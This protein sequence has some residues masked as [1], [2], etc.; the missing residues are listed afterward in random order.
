[1]TAPVRDWTSHELSYLEKNAASKTIRV[2][3]QALRRS[4]SSIESKLRALGLRGTNAKPRSEW[5]PRER[6]EMTP[7][8]LVRAN[9]LHLRDLK[10]A[11][12]TWWHRFP[13]AE[14][15]VLP[16]RAPASSFSF[17]SCVGSPAAMCAE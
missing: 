17:S 8:A 4:E 13:A 3:G 15:D 14:A 7:E 16:S 2:M 11:G 10:A 9:A 1:V 5:M 6:R 12:H